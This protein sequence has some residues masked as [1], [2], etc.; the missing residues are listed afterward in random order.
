MSLSKLT[1]PTTS[2]VKTEAVH[3]PDA[4]ESVPETQA[5]SL[6]P[7]NS[8]T[9]TMADVLNTALSTESARAGNGFGVV[10]LS[11]GPSGGMFCPAEF[12]PQ[13]VQDALPSGKKPICG[14]LLGY[15]LAVSAWPVGYTDAPAADKNAAKSKPVYAASVS[16]NDA[17]VLPL[18]LKAA[19]NYQFTKSADKAKFDYATSSA[20]HI[21]VAVE[22]LVYEASLGQPI[23]VASP[24]NYGCVEATLQNIQKLIDPKTGALG[25][26]PCSIR[27]VSEE[28]TSKGGF[29][30]KQHSLDISNTAGQE[31]SAK[32]WQSFGAWK[33]EALK[34]PGTVQSVR[35]WISAQDRKV[36]ADVVAALKAAASL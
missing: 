21:R 27:P 8:G 33:A 1:K 29:T 19:R 7:E 2:N 15:R 18:A 36:T 20:G 9:V 4:V 10:N 12:L 6:L 3:V 31:Q 22:L 13:E 5:L 17:S 16:A 24:A 35:D 26:F 11:G 25:Q 30:W 14:V 23:V 34:D 32:D 28:K